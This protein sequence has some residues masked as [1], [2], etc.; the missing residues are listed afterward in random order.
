MGLG[1]GSLLLMPFYIWLVRLVVVLFCN[2]IGIRSSVIVLSASLCYLIPYTQWCRY[3]FSLVDLLL[4]FLGSSSVHI[5]MGNLCPICL[6]RFA[7]WLISYT[8]L[9]AGWLCCHDTQNMVMVLLQQQNIC[10]C[11]VC[12]WHIRDVVL[13]LQ[14]H[15]V[16]RSSFVAM[17]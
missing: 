17:Q 3:Y 16:T 6:F 10:S 9:R 15:R 2:G 12:C 5:Y 4:V 14:R 13:L 7:A 11:F 1:P 8:T